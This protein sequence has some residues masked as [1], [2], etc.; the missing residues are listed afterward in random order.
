MSFIKN[1]TRIFSLE[2]WPDTRSFTLKADE[3]LIHEDDV[4]QIELIP[5]DNFE[6]A[7]QEVERI[8]NFAEEHFDGK[9]WTEVYERS[10]PPQRLVDRKISF[11]DFAIPLFKDGFKLKDMRY[12]GL[13]SSGPYPALVKNDFTIFLSLNSKWI[14]A[15]YFP[16]EIDDLHLRTETIITLSQKYQLVLVDWLKLLAVDA[17]FRKDTEKYIAMLSPQ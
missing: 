14:E 8:R 11:F 2:P 16:I 6:Y 12:I 13:P 7:K 10:E 1:I 9:G 5:A 3:I 15:V 17:R 4:R